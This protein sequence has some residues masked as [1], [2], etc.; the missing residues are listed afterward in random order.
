[1]DADTNV[2]RKKL[3]RELKDM[4][5]DVHTDRFHLDNAI[6]G[7]KQQLRNILS[8]H[9]EFQLAYHNLQ[10]EVL[11]LLIIIITMVLFCTILTKNLA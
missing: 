6:R 11:F 9:K 1:M 2:N 3:Q 7:D 8:D 5:K 10:P 4:V